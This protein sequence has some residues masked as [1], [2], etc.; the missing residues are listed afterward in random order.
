MGSH[1]SQCSLPCVR[2]L[3]PRI[4]FGRSHDTNTLFAGMQYV[5]KDVHYCFLACIRGNMA[6]DITPLCSYQ[7]MKVLYES[8]YR[9][10]IQAID[11]VQSASLFYPSLRTLHPCS[12][13]RRAS[14]PNEDCQTEYCFNVTGDPDKIAEVARA[15]GTVVQFAK[16]GDT[17]LIVPCRDKGEAVDS[18]QNFRWVASRSHINSTR[19][20]LEKAN[21]PFTEGMTGNLSQENPFPRESSTQS[22]TP[23]P[24]GE[25][26]HD[27]PPAAYL[28]HLR[29]ALADHNQADYVDITHLSDAAIAMRIAGR[30]SAQRNGNED[31]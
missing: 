8:S 25:G 14:G 30:L 6:S 18:E 2:K 12:I 29:K 24:K 7:K 5:K 22:T 17:Y 4:Q 31:W 9:K 28:T 15:T 23:P 3:K 10:I 19:E 27:S 11:L 16:S 13:M 1:H 20:A 26:E 21:I